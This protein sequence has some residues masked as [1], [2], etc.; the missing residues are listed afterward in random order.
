M[1]TTYL[2]NEINKTLPIISLDKNILRLE[3]DAKRIRKLSFV[4]N[5]ILG[6]ACYSDKERDA[7]ITKGE[8]LG[9]LNDTELKMLNDGWDLRNNL[10]KKLL[11]DL[12]VFLKK[13]NSEFKKDGL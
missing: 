10:A 11:I 12:R 3:L 4:M 2:S 6:N 9:S 13:Y 8:K 7:Q 1:K 5:T